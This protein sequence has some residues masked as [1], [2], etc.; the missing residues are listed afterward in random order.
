MVVNLWT[1]NLNTDGNYID[2]LPELVEDDT[3]DET[4]AKIKGRAIDFGYFK[5]QRDALKN[6]VKEEVGD[7]LP[8]DGSEP[9]KGNLNM[10]DHE[11]N[12][13]TKITMTPGENNVFNAAGNSIV[14]VKTPLFDSFA[15]NKGY[16][17]KKTNDN[18]NI[19]NTKVDEKF[20]K[21][22]I[23]KFEQRNI[24]SN[25]KENVF[26]KVMDDGLFIEDDDDI[27]NI[28]KVDKDFHKVNKQTY[29]FRIDYDSSIG[30]YSSRLGVNVV[31]L[32]IGFYILCFEMYF[33]DKIDHQNITVNCLSGT[34]QILSKNTKYSSD[35]SR[36]I[37]NFRKTVDRP[38]DD[39]LDIDISLK[40]KTGEFYT[41]TSSIYVV[42]YGVE[43]LGTDVDPNVWDRLY[44]VNDQ[45]RLQFELPIDM[46]NKDIEN[47]NDL[48]INNG[49]NM[50]NRQIK[51]L[52]DGNENADAVNVKQLNEMETNI[53][54]YVTNYVKNY[55]TD[56]IGKENPLIKFIYRNLIR[57]DSKLSLIKELYFPDS[58]QGRTQNSYEYYTNGDNKGDVT[59][60]LTFQH[61]TSTGDDNMTIHLKWAWYN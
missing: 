57:N 55:F 49:L 20:V 61:K 51:K 9:M 24:S 7:D 12:N 53:V 34:L 35:H 5:K 44:H 19:I 2:G 60:Y 46:V 15:A 41:P 17:D 22:E 14:N 40:N 30:Y 50:N 38:S 39:E 18:R 47:V 6:F 36:S 16:V 23:D 32:P 54:N 28:G 26:K 27:K 33:T 8:K 1:G 45:G 21:D 25:Y 10:N 58:N 56:Q 3:S 59:F 42:V 52:G 43:G 48:S 29:H 31:Y 37:F 11:I 13:I 4:L